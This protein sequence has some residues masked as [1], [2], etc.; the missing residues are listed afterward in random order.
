MILFEVY[1]IFCKDKFKS[2]CNFMAHLATEEQFVFLGGNNSNK[3]C[4][5]LD[6]ERVNFS[7]INNLNFKSL[8][9]FL[10]F[11]KDKKF[12]YSCNKNKTPNQQ[13]SARLVGVLSYD[14]SASDKL[15]NYNVFSSCQKTTNQ[16][17]K[18]SASKTSSY[19]YANAIKSSFISSKI[20]KINSY[21]I[22]NAHGY[23]KCLGNGSEKTK[24]IIEKYNEFYKNSKTKKINICPETFPK[25]KL[26]DH[27][28]YSDYIS[29]FSKIHDDI[30]SG[31]YYQINFLRY[32]DVFFQ[33]HGRY[34]NKTSVFNSIIQAFI[35]YSEA[36]SCIIRSENDLIVSFS[37]ERFV[38]IKPNHKNDTLIINTYPIKG[39]LKKDPNLKDKKAIRLNNQS[40]N[41]LSNSKKDTYELN[42]IIDLM[43]NDLFQISQSRSVKVLDPGTVQSFSTVYHRIANINSVLDNDKTIKDI[44]LALFPSGS[45]TGTPKLEAIQAIVEYEQKSRGYFMG[46]VFAVFCDGSFDSSV[47]IRTLHMKM[48][49]LLIT[50]KDN[51][52]HGRGSDRYF[53]KI[54]QYA[55]GSGIV[56]LS[57]AHQEYLEINAKCAIWDENVDFIIKNKTC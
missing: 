6:F 22:F 49:N 21:I 56:S 7:E 33:N 51:D 16:S 57:S 20:Y 2:Y 37:P 34:Y 50:S 25:F 26:S 54:G 52:C 13:S 38:H 36:M 1:K 46:N 18:G 9:E 31:R 14:Q 12:Y 19:A 29:N 24:S 40:L 11:N 47:L 15:E 42:M 3:L 55:A 44:F 32:F 43:R 39:T 4:L 27:K 45:I 30:T 48:S 35:V 17:I 53:V 8:Y 23:A 5:S 41:K 10:D 28:T